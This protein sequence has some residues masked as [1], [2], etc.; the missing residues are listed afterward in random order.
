MSNDNNQ[1]ED[2][3]SYTSLFSEFLGTN[4]TFWTRIIENYPLTSILQL[5][6]LFSLYGNDQM[7]QKDIIESIKFDNA[8]VT[9]H[10]RKLEDN[11]LVT[12]CEDPDNRR[13]NIIALTTEGKKITKK[14]WDY[15]I[16]R[17]NEII[18]DLDI[19]HEELVNI[20]L[21]I[22]KNSYEYNSNHS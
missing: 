6:I 2:Y 19:S 15:Q 17:E 16:D 3:V 11:N 5:S 4:K 20:M 18:K 8:V 13:E 7:H 9:R 1:Y 21:K 10:I 14:L 22:I 12:R